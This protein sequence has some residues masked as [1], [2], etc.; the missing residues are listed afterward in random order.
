MRKKPT[1]E[2][3]QKERE[4]D[5]LCD[6]Y[7]DKFNSGFPLYAI[8]KGPCYTLDEALETIKKCLETGVPAEPKG[9]DYNPEY[10]Y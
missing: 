8:G 2:Q 10:I 9:F 4:L 6:E 7:L 3:L 5:A 1:K